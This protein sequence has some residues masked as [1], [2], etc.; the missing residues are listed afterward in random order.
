MKETSDEFSPP[1]AGSHQ[2][3]PAG[4]SAN[5]H[6][7]ARVNTKEIKR[8]TTWTGRVALLR[9]GLR[10][11]G[12][13]WGGVTGSCRLMRRKS[14]QISSFV[15]P[16]RP[17]RGLFRVRACLFVSLRLRGVERRGHTGPPAE[18]IHQTP[19]PSETPLRSALLLALC[20]LCSRSSLL[21]FCL[22]PPFSPIKRRTVVFLVVLGGGGRGGTLVSLS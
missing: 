2:H 20:G 13:S 3:R 4:K 19:V 17:C 5:V 7:S 10:P 8:I 9:R 22:R 21:L 1:A 11:R 12:H 16:H 14:C 6:K 15:P 18:P